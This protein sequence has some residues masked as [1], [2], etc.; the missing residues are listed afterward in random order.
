[1]TSSDNKRT[2]TKLLYTMLVLV[3]LLLVSALYYLQFRRS[4]KLIYE[5]SET[6]PTV[7]DLPLLGHTHWFIGGP[8]SKLKN[9]HSLELI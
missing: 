2:H 9:Y 1:M 6:L 3:L 4:R 5:F 7:G 8:E